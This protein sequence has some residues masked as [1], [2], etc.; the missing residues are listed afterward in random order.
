MEF[1]PFVPITVPVATSD[2]LKGDF[3]LKIASSQAVAQFLILAWEDVNKN[4]KLDMDE[5]RAPE[6]YQIIKMDGLFFGLRASGSV[7]VPLAS[8]SVVTFP[9]ASKI[10]NF[11]FVMPELDEPPIAEPEPEPEPT[12]PPA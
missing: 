8:E 11:R 7:L 2:Y 5:V 1:N 10:K 3:M 12:A 9:D 4:Q 6:T